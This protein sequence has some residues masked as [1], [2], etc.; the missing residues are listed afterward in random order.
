MSLL[1]GHEVSNL[2]RC[3]EG[4]KLIADAEGDAHKDLSISAEPEV[5][6]AGGNKHLEEYPP[7][8]VEALRVL[9][10]WWSETYE[11]WGF[12]T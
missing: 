2:L 10:W 9:K 1:P 6:Y 11:C 7:E 8:T 12:W 5:I 3:L 4:L